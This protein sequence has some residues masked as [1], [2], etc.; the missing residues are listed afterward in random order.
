GNVE[1][2]ADGG[3]IFRVGVG[4]GAQVRDDGDEVVGAGGDGDGDAGGDVEGFGLGGGEVG[5]GLIVE[6]TNKSIGAVGDGTCEKLDLD[7]LGGGGGH[8]AV[9]GDGDLHFAG[10]AGTGG[11]GGGEG[12]CAERGVEINAGEELAGFKVVEEYVMRA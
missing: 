8:V 1:G 6:G 12:D 4:G 9:V 3:V 10:G 11:E 5:D 2:G 7:F